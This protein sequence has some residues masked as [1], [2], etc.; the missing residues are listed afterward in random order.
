MNVTSPAW[1]DTPTSF[2]SRSHF[3]S[4]ANPTTSRYHARLLSRSFT[5]NDGEASVI[6]R[7]PDFFAAGFFPAFTGRRAAFFGA[8]LFVFFVFVAGMTVPPAP[9]LS[10]ESTATSDDAGLARLL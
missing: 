6:L 7:P 8:D 9:M 10:R 1:S 2:P 3:S 4:I 5:V